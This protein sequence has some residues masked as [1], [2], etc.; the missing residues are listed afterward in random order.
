MFLAKDFYVEDTAITE[1][2]TLLGETHIKTEDYV[3]K[4]E[5]VAG[6]NA[7]ELESY[8]FSS[9]YEDSKTYEQEVKDLTKQL[10]DLAT[11]LQLTEGEIYQ[12]EAQV[13]T[14]KAGDSL[15]KIAQMYGVSIEELARWNNIDNIN[16]IYPGQT[17]SIKGISL[18]DVD[19]EKFIVADE[20]NAATKP[21]DLEPTT[22]SGDVPVDTDEGPAP[23]PATPI[24]EV[25]ELEPVEEPEIVES[26]PVYPEEPG[27][28][29]I[30]NAYANLAQM[31]PAAYYQLL[32][33]VAEEASASADGANAVAT[34]V[35]NRLCTPGFGSSV[36]EVLSG[37]FLPWLAPH[38]KSV[39]EGYLNNPG[40]VPQYV[41][42]GV[43]RAL[44][45][46][47][48]VDNKVLYYSGDG[49]HN[50]FRYELN[51]PRIYT[52]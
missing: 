33:I 10:S 11:S 9:K 22:L 50:Y 23:A 36:G 30:S 31:D 15:S 27:N 4:M 2:A 13:Y 37:G 29:N 7:P 38:R 41:I 46:H 12:Q 44:S 25:P 26:Y 45:G 16:L 48:V 34:V 14:V 49:V 21:Q 42:D 5:N 40:S 18:D 20:S 8:N 17:L 19:L 6:I 3:K 39:Y 43:N 47:S 24:E 51:G 32:A 35:I 1:E 28:G 52:V